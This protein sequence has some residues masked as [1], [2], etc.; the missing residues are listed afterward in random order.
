MAKGRGKDQKARKKRSTL[1]TKQ[2]A[3]QSSKKQA[4]KLKKAAGSNQA[5]LNWFPA[6]NA[7]VRMCSAKLSTA[8]NMRLCQGAAGAGESSRN[9]T[10]AGQASNANAVSSRHVEPT[11]TK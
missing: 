7:E 4:T 8:L 11:S 9:A 6:A 1:S 5:T 2:K 10:D 3:A